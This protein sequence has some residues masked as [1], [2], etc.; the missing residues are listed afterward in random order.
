MSVALHSSGTRHHMTVIYGTHWLSSGWKSKKWPKLT[1]N[2]I[3]RTLYFR[4]HISYD[5]HVCYTCMYRRIISPG[6]FSFFFQ[7]FDFRDHWERGGKVVKGQKMAQNDKNSVCLTPYLRNSISYDCDFW[8]TCVKWWYL[9][10]IFSFFK[11]LIFGV[12]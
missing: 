6:I 7:N 9:Q 10:Q 4:N 12:C 3:C 8:Y 2:F 1:K 5:L 11:I